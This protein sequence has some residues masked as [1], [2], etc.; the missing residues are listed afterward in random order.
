MTRTS[1]TLFLVAIGLSLGII[2]ALVDSIPE[3][4]QR[5]NHLASIILEENR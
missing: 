1:E 2:I 3:R 5:L 4:E